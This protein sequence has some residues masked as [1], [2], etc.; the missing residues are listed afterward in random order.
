M[1]SK[2]PRYYTFHIPS[3]PIS[4]QSPWLVFLLNRFRTVQNTTFDRYT[5]TYYVKQFNHLTTHPVF[6]TLALKKMAQI[7]HRHN[8]IKF[9][10]FWKI[11]SSISETFEK[12]GQRVIYRRDRLATLYFTGKFEW[13]HSSTVSVMVEKS[14]LRWIDERR[15]RFWKKSVFL[16]RSNE[17]KCEPISKRIVDSE[18]PRDQ[19][20]IAPFRYLYFEIS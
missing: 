19:W 9:L 16:N 17:S 15:P 2:L 20:D 1:T 3:L 7:L 6:I 13:P 5:S 8:L 18:R 14:I 11:K 4:Y 12:R 10:L